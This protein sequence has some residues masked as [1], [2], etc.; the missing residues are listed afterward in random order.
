MVPSGAAALEIPVGLGDAVIGPPALTPNA[1]A[2]CAYNDLACLQAA[3]GI[4]ASNSSA[5]VCLA[6]DTACLSQVQSTFVAPPTEPPSSPTSPGAVSFCGPNSLQWITGIDN[7]VVLVSAG[8][9]LF[10][11]IAVASSGKRRRR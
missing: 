5:G 1:P 4:T 11:L 8:V 10:L 3:T 9:G 7:C 2:T 6:G